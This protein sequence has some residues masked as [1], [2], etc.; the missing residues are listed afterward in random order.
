MNIFNLFR[1]AKPEQISD[2]TPRGVAKSIIPENHGTAKD[3]NETWRYIY[4]Q[5][6]NLDLVGK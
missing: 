2:L 6:R 5:R 3:F 1:K 4:S